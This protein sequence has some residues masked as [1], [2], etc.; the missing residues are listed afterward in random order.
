MDETHMHITLTKPISRPETKLRVNESNPSKI[1][2]CFLEVVIPQ[3]PDEGAW[4]LQKYPDDF[5]D[6][7][8][9]KSVSHFCYPCDIR[10]SVVQV[11]SFVLTGADSKWT[12]GYCRHTPDAPTAICLL[13]SLPWHETFYDLLNRIAEITHR[14]EDSDLLRFLEQLYTAQVPSPGGTIVLPG[15][16]GKKVV[17]FACSNHTKL[18]SIPE[19][20]N[21][22][23]YFNAVDAQTMMILFASMLNERRI[24]ITSNKLSRLSACVQSANALIYPMHWQHIF[25][26]ILPT[27]LIDYLHAPMPFL[28]GVPSMVLERAT[29]LDLSEVVVLHADQN[30]IE[31]PFDDLQN[32]PPE[33]VSSL[34]RRLKNSNAM[35]GDRMAR[36]FLHSLVQLIGGYRDALKFHLGEKITFDSDAFIQTRTPSMQ[37]FLE[38]MLQLQIFQQFIEERLDMLN[39]GDGFSDEFELEVNVYADKNSTKLRH[40]YKEWMNNMR[41]EGGAFIKSVKNKPMSNLKSTKKER[42]HPDG[43]GDE[44]PLTPQHYNLLEVSEGSDDNPPDDS[45]EQLSDG[46]S[47]LLN[48]RRISMDLMGDLQDLIFRRCSVSDI[49]T[50]QT[51]GATPEKLSLS[52]QEDLIQL[53]ADDQN[54]DEQFDPLLAKD[55]PSGL[56][57]SP[58]RSP[59]TERSSSLPLAIEGSF[60]AINTTN[61]SPIHLQ[62]STFHPPPMPFSSTIAPPQHPYVEMQH[63]G[64]YHQPLVQS[65]HNLLGQTNSFQPQFENASVGQISMQKYQVSNPFAVDRTSTPDLSFNMQ[66]KASLPVDNSS[67]GVPLFKSMR[68]QSAINPWESQSEQKSTAKKQQSGWETFN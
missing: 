37:P 60:P 31:T 12:F 20:R 57:T 51:T 3:V 62:H 36:A 2:D 21:V 17:K 38:R 26:P 7:E 25:I 47:P 48:V 67:T 56:K 14:K 65:Q 55:L 8:I 59:R 45:E 23:E 5:S 32:L 28:I 40:Q 58:P 39:S 68:S 41:K 18:P 4:V 16:D 46:A 49:S 6:D 44:S 10:S 30:R 50:D 61:Q 53:D 54:S 1:F 63:R 43:V 33:I 35:L 11:F 29:K 19:N 9:L 13:S 24:L 42:L 66:Q 15:E 52:L 64:F 34:K 22:S 27:N